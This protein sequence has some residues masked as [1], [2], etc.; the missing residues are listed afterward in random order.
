[1]PDYWGR[2]KLQVSETWGGFT[3]WFSSSTKS[4]QDATQKISDIRSKSMKS[5]EDAK[6]SILSAREK[7]DQIQKEVNQ[8]LED[9]Q[10]AK[11]A[12]TEAK[13][14]VDELLNLGTN[15]KVNGDG[16]SREELEKMKQELEQLLKSDGTGK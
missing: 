10:S 2:I 14:S 4:V 5:F 8:K 6:R 11:K 16:L 3:G 7:I 1:M 12:I 13:K 15:E 9:I